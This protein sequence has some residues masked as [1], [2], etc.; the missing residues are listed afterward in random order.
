[1]I[2][3]IGFKNFKA[4]R[5]TTLPLG[6]FTL[7]V[8]PNG[9]GKSTVLQAL[10]LFA[11]G[12]HSQQAFNLS[13]FLSAG[14]QRESSTEVA[15]TL[16]WGAPLS[17]R[18]S[19]I[20]WMPQKLQAIVH[21][22]EQGKPVSELDRLALNAY[23][24]DMKIYG[25]QPER[26]AAPVA[27]TPNAELTLEGGGLVAVLDR[28]RDQDPERFETLN[29]ELARLLPEFDRILFEMPSPGNRT[30]L[31]RTR[32]GRHSIRAGDL[33]HGTLF[34]L[35]MLT[36]A[37]LPNP[38]SLVGLEEPDHG[39]HPRLLREVRDALYRLS[40]PDQFGES[41]PPVQVI[42]T[43]QSPY[44]LDLFKEHPEEIVI[45][46]KEGLEARFERLV[47]RPDINEILAD[48]PLGEVWYSGVLGGVPG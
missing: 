6:R 17:G 34:A 22:N 44:F 29:R 23:L 8:G 35:T 28:L 9:S 2:E 15:A 21:L 37:H 13:G 45:A 40:Y 3:V 14:L 48:A 4:L 33:S 18:L 32:Q 11:E 47:D 19:R 5:D 42:A 46:Q 1:M 25:F 43:T 31:L 38:P 20:V 30:F 26:I 10:R 12:A 7:L 39:L 36:L 16:R 41:R 24:C 27:L